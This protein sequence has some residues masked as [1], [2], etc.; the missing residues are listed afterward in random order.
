MP[1]STLSALVGA[2][3]GVLVVMAAICAISLLNPLWLGAAR[4][5]SPAPTLA[6]S[7]LPNP[8]D[9]EFPVPPPTRD[10]PAAP[11]P[12]LSPLPTSPD[13]ACGGP[14]RMTIAL[15][16]VDSR[17]ADYARPTRTDAIVLVTVNFKT[18]TAALLSFPRDLYVPLPNLKEYGIDQSRLN[19][20]YLYGEVYD[21][22]GGGPAELKDTIALNFAIRVDRYL[23]LNFGAF[24]AAVDAL[25][26]IDVDV[27]E[28]IYDPQY[29][30]EDGGTTVFEL[31]A[32]L[33]HMDGK[34]ALRYARTRHQDDDYHR[35]QRQ[36]L[37]LL[38]IRD[39]LLSP[40]VIP[41]IPALLQSL[42]NLAQTDLAPEEIATLACIGPQIDRS[43]ITSL[44]IDGTM[45]IPWTTPS[46]GRVS[47]PNREAI[48]P[49][50]EQFLGQ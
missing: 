32:G 49:I 37:V 38:A 6:A 12:T 9:V 4:P 21:V 46:G 7:P 34:T 48:T 45:V 14:E 26:G 29:P 36:Q 27:P 5:D 3:F 2:A 31:P 50:V 47:I 30:A 15:L 22:P 23:M 8:D 33:Q 41:Q 13:A 11:T 24:E 10:G 39:K 35:I 25:G 1:R 20:A 16:G 17:E 18:R 28:A 42:S 44:A 43:A 40:E 19:T